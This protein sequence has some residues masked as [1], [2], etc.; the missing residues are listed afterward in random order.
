MLADAEYDKLRETL[1]KA[2]SLVVLHEGAYLRK[3]PQPTLFLHG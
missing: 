2:G 1:K 3:A